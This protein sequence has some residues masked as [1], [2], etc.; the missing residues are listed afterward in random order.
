MVI[1]SV[2]IF[3]L[4]YAPFSILDIKLFFTPRKKIGKLREV[5]T[6]QTKYAVTKITSNMQFVLR[7]EHL[8]HGNCYLIKF[9]SLKLDN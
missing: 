7:V 8:V 5:P 2:H 6:R 3:D 9:T 4:Q 1:L